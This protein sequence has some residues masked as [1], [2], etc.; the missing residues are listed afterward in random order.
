MPRGN[1]LREEGEYHLPPQCGAQLSGTFFIIHC[2]QCLNCQLPRRATGILSHH[3]VEDGASFGTTSLRAHD[4]CKTRPRLEMRW[5]GDGFS[6]E[7]SFSLGYASGLQK[8]LAATELELA[9]R[10]K[11]SSLHDVLCSL[12]QRELIGGAFLQTPHL[13]EQH[14]RLD[15]VRLLRQAL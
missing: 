12:Q 2:K 5:K 3:F 10:R 14:Q 11:A 8:S 9:D 13:R 15:T 6:A 7:G 4:E 1:G